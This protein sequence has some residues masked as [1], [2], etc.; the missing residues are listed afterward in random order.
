M[1]MVHPTGV[2]PV[3][4]GFGSRYSIQLSYG[5]NITFKYYLSLAV[6]SSS[7]K[8]CSY[9]FRCASALQQLVKRSAIM[10]MRKGL[11][12]ADAILLAFADDVYVEM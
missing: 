11:S 2:E 10:I 6:S 7:A 12:W 5:C 8:H 9:S 1:E 3:T 4:N